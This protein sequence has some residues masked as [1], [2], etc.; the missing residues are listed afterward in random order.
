MLDYRG[1]ITKQYSLGVNGGQ[2]AAILDASK[3]GTNGFLR[4][5][6]ACESIGPSPW[7]QGEGKD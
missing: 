6:E 5:L 7:T 1:I 4:R 3:S 2:I